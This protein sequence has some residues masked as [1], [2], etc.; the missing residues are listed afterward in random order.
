MKLALPT[1]MLA[2]AAL[3]VGM[4][5]APAH[6]AGVN[7][8]HKWCVQKTYN[9]ATECRYDALARCEQFQRGADDGDCVINPKWAAL[10]T[11]STTGMKPMEK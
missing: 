7:Q 10:H 8:I 9:S 3:A 1:T 4:S 6:A 11:R 2:A 5:L